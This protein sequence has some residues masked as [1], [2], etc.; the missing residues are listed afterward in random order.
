M[1]AAPANHDQP[2][3]QARH[4]LHFGHHGAGSEKWR[5][6]AARPLP[7]G[8]P[9]TGVELAVATAVT[10]AVDGCRS[11]VVTALATRV[12]WRSA[13][14]VVRPSRVALV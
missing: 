3:L 5:G 10:V 2:R 9:L 12:S 13:K 11:V 7:D 14:L 1:T 6:D 8:Y 4:H